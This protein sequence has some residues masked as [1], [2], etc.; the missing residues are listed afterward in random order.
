MAW[1][2]TR[3]SYLERCPWYGGVDRGFLDAH[4]D[5]EER[6]ARGQQQ[7]Q[8]SICLLWHWD[9]EWGDEPPGLNLPLIRPEEEDGTSNSI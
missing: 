4:A 7:R 2:P 5:A 3:N 6:M 8:C 1:K 9:D